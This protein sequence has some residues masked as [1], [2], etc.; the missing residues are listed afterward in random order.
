[1]GRIL[2][3]YTYKT[4]KKGKT[5]RG[6]VDFTS[7]VA[8]LFK[9]SIRRQREIKI[10]NLLSGHFKYKTCKENTKKTDLI[11]KNEKTW[12]EMASKCKHKFQA[13]PRQMQDL[14]IKSAHTKLHPSAD[15]SNRFRPPNNRCVNKQ[16]NITRNKVN[17]A[18]VK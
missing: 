15:C 3:N 1:M 10:K 2:V 8:K 7:C 13:I 16:E 18:N 14:H 12:N 6:L 9:I 17:D 11:F 4:R 5:R